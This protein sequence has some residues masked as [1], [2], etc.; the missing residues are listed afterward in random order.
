MAPNSSIETFTRIMKPVVDQLDKLGIPYQ[1]TPKQFTSYNAAWTDAWPASQLQVTQP[2]DIQ[3]SR[4]I[5]RNIWNDPND[6]NSSFS[7]IQAIADAGYDIT[8]FGITPGNPFN[9]D[10]AVSPAL[11]QL[12]SFVSTGVL[13]PPNPT[14]AELAATQSKVMDD[15]MQPLREAAPADKFGGSYINEANVM[16]P[17]WQQDFYGDKY[18]RLLT[19]KQ[20][21]DPSGLFYATAGVGTEGWEVRTKDQGIQTQNGPLCRL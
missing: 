6:F 8:T 18:P 20:K 7:A 3:A 13:L 10:N 14:P 9:V 4:L 21:W 15:L 19:I 2:E 1:N 17:N 16:E 5:P 11:R 12:M